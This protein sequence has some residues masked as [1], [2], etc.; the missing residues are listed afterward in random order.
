MFLLRVKYIT[1]LTSAIL[2][3]HMAVAYW[4]AASGYYATELCIWFILLYW[5]ARH[6]RILYHLIFWGCILV[7][8]VINPLAILFMR[9]GMCR[10]YRAIKLLESRGIYGDLLPASAPDHLP[11]LYF[12]HYFLFLV[13]AIFCCFALID[14]FQNLR[15]EKRHYGKIDFINIQISKSNIPSVYRSLRVRLV[16]LVAGV[17]ISLLLFW[18]A[19][20][21][22]DVLCANLGCIS[23][24][25]LSLL[26]YLW[27]Y[28][29]FNFVLVYL[30]FDTFL[31]I[32]QHHRE[33][34][35]Y[36]LMAQIDSSV[37]INPISYEIFKK[38]PT[39]ILNEP[40]FYGNVLLPWV[41]TQPKGITLNQF[42]LFI[43]LFMYFV[44]C[45]F[46]TKYSS[47]NGEM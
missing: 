18:V 27:G 42:T 36:N 5:F 10:L 13:T 45:Y 2:L 19:Y 31:F 33:K 40:A 38:S 26:C 44:V 6:Y 3:L 17:P 14:Y 16:L 35:I 24:V 46:V 29:V 4:Y 15:K 1:I 12:H 43:L 21:G 39:Y 23:L 25:I 47:Q 34:V 8:G 20:S 41:Q 7:C 30:F 32:G 9:Y 11:L 28:N 22:Y 37:S